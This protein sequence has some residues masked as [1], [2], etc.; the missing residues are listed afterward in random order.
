M[1]TVI[2]HTLLCLGAGLLGFLCG[3]LLN[4]ITHSINS[5]ELAGRLRDEMRINEEALI[6]TRKNLLAEQSK[7]AAL[8]EECLRLESGWQES[9]SRLMA[10]EAHLAELSQ[11]LALSASELEARE[12]ALNKAL[13]EIQRL[14]E[15]VRAM[16]EKLDEVHA[17][18]ASA[19]TDHAAELAGLQELSDSKG[20]ELAK[21]IFRLKQLELRLREYEEKSSAGND[22]SAQLL[23][24]ASDLEWT[25][26]QW[27]STAMKLEE[28]EARHQQLLLE[29]QA[30]VSASR[31]HITDLEMMARQIPKQDV[32]MSLNPDLT[33]VQGNKGKHSN[34]LSGK[35]EG[36]EKDDLKKIFGI[37]PRLENLLN[38]YGIFQFQQIAKWTEADIKHFDEKLTDFRG[39]IRRDD[40]VA[41]AKRELER[42]YGEQ[43]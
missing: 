33:L 10:N 40:W 22:T 23:Q 29:R 41:S 14:G 5:V 42:K 6:A 1:W 36:V 31:A 30:E 32:K 34:S 12:V 27:Q 43:V 24:M 28:L 8:E 3:W 25:R 4:H 2:L 38:S 9:D 35:D 26:S 21:S 18:L 37:G 20:R 13:S 15:S 16:E 7:V 11:D 19:N 39:R 17:E